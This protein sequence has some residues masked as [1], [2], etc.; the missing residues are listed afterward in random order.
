MNDRRMDCAEIRDVL[1][2]GSAPAGPDVE[3]HLRDCAPCTELLRDHGT[4][5]RALSKS[6]APGTDSAELWTSVESALGAETGARAWMRSRRAPIR[7]LVAVAVAV[8]MVVL[9]SRT[10]GGPAELPI[11]WVVAFALVGLVGLAGLLAPLGRPQPAP[12]MR[13]AL[14]GGALS[15]PLVYALASQLPSTAASS[16]L[17]FVEQAVGCFA[18]GVF[19]ALPFLVV[20]WLLE[21]NDRPW[22]TVLAATGAIAGLVANAALALH[23]PN[24]DPAHLTVG[25]AT[26]GIAFA[27]L[28]ALWAIAGKRRTR[29]R[30]RA[31]E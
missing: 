6:T 7:L 10:S 8:V 25:H 17:G 2:A 30:S 21:R 29:G 24:T 27:F 9:G 20:V 19:L 15:L 1:L 16:E 3:A 11:A 12:R 14:I 4:L 26:I 18:Y 13:W 28:G 22:L 5:G 31:L 23:C